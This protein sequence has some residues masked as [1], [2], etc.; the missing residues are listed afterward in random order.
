LFDGLIMILDVRWDRKRLMKKFGEP[1]EPCS[2][3]SYAILKCS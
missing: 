2:S 3:S 1:S